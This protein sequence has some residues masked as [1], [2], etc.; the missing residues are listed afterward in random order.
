V[1]PATQDGRPREPL[2]ELVERA[3]AGDTE[4]F[5]RLYREHSPRVFALCLRL[6]GGDRSEAT[7]LLQDAFI[8]AWRAL[9]GFRGDAPFSTW[10]HRLTVNAMLQNVRGTRRR[11]AR[12]L[13]MESTTHTTAEYHGREPG[14]VMDLENAIARLPE[15]ARTAFVLHHIEGYQHQEIAEQL[16]IAIGTVKAQVH[17]ARCLLIKALER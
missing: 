16:G 8:S 5:E 4:A 9:P 14:L 17:R 3:R 11:E 1:S 15:G 13:Q 7:A 12:V 2:P 6:T 10:M